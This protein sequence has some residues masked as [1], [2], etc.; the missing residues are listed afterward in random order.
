[1]EVLDWSRR[2]IREWETSGMEEQGCC[3]R[4]EA[5]IH[6]QDTVIE[7]RQKTTRLQ[8]MAQFLAVALLLLTSVALALLLTVVLGERG[9]QP[10]V[11]PV[12]HLSGF[13]QQ[14]LKDDKN[15]SAM[16]TAPNGNNTDGG[17]LKWENETGNAFCQG[18][19]KYSSGNLVV[20]RNGIYRVFLQITYESKEDLKCN[21]DEVLRLINKVLFIRDTYD[22]D[23]CLLSS[24]DTVSCSMEQWSKSLY[25]AGLFFLEAN[26]RLHVTSSRPELIVKK[27]YQVLFG[28]EL[29]H[30]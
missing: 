3:C 27:Q 4:L 11:Q 21:R 9:R 30:Q 17:Y 19:F 15:P 13:D 23:V 1:M 12:S 29:L 20:P 18:G 10:M 28:A 22:E 5:G 24:V 6:R 25:T 16:L 14:Q 8:R 7:L 26:S 2:L